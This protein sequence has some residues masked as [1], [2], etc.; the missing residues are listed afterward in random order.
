MN[1]NITRLARA[2]KC[3]ARGANGLAS[4]RARSVSIAC[5][6]IEPNPQAVAL[7]KFRR[8]KQARVLEKNDAFI[9]NKEI[10]SMIAVRGNSQSR[11]RGASP[12]PRLHSRRENAPLLLL[13][14]P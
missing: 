12:R 8:E 7:K 4:A 5:K 9:G 14:R 3:E 1:R 13:R 2:G 10:R 11:P 6:A